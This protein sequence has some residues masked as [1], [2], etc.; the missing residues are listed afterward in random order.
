[1]QLGPAYPKRDDEPYVAYSFMYNNGRVPAI[2]VQSGIDV[3]LVQSGSTVMPSLCVRLGAVLHAS[4]Q[5]VSATFAVHLN[6][7]AGSP[8]NGLGSIAITFCETQCMVQ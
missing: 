8:R 1:M 7:T 4:S 2:L 3:M 5:P 6:P